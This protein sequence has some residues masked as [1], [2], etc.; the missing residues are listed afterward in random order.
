[1][2]TVYH[3]L[4]RSS[5]AHSTTITATCNLSLVVAVTVKMSDGN[6]FNSCAV[7]INVDFPEIGRHCLIQEIW[8]Q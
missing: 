7:R 4:L 6:V 1:M 2:L 5:D 3:G 8:Y